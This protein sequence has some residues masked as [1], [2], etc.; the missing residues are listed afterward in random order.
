MRVTL[1]KFLLVDTVLLIIIVLKLSHY[2]RFVIY[3]DPVF[4]NITYLFAKKTSR[5]FYMCSFRSQPVPGTT[6]LYLYQYKSVPYLSVPVQKSVDQDYMMDV[7][8]PIRPFYR[9]N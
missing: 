1:I 3:I 5:F 7:F 8:M 4:L 6:C 9:Y 2:H